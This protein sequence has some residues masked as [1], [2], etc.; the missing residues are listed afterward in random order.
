MYLYQFITSVQSS[1]EAGKEWRESANVNWVLEDVHYQ[2]ISHLYSLRQATVCH[3]L[4]TLIMFSWLFPNT[5]CSLILYIIYYLYCSSSNLDKLVSSLSRFD[6]ELELVFWDMFCFDFFSFFPSDGYNCVCSHVTCHP[7]WTVPCLSPGSL[8][9]AF[10]Q[11][12]SRQCRSC[13]AISS[14][15][16][17]LGLWQLCLLQAHKSMSSDW[18]MAPTAALIGA[19]LQ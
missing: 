7:F 12:L 8:I 1:E 17:L 16:W 6:E 9:C 15:I 3:L 2:I 18:L 5:F 11:L 13:V 19:M 14:Y 10:C 4:F